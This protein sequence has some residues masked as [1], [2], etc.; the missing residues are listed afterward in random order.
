[1]ALRDRAG[2]LLAFSPHPQNPHSIIPSLNMTS[3]SPGI[4]TPAPAD[5][6]PEGLEALPTSFALGGSWR[7]PKG[8]GRPMD[9]P[10]Y[11]FQHDAGL[12]LGRVREA[13][14]RPMEAPTFAYDAGWEG[15][16]S[17]TL[18]PL[19][20]GYKR[21]PRTEPTFGGGAGGG[22]WPLARG[23]PARRDP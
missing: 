9:V 13:R 18:A 23:G 10:T 22:G 16:G 20:Y 2:N 8:L 15:A 19:A 14:L 6:Q 7:A 5:S 12:P 21:D 1:M 4:H 3:P 11:K 17:Q